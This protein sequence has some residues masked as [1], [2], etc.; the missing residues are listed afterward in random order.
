MGQPIHVLRG[1]NANVGAVAF[2]P[3][4][5]R[6][7]SGG[8][9]TTVV[10]WDLEKGRPIRIRPSL[11]MVWYLAVHPDNT[12]VASAGPAGVL[13]WDLNSGRQVNV[14]TEL[15]KQ[16]NTEWVGFTRDGKELVAAGPNGA[17]GLWDTKSGKLLRPFE[18]HKGRVFSAALSPDGRSLLS[19]GEDKTVRLW[20][21]DN[22]E[23]VRQFRGVKDVI[24]AVAFS[25]DG[26]RVLA[27]GRDPSILLWDTETGNGPITM[28]VSGVGFWDAA[29]A[30]DGKRILTASGEG[31]DNRLS[32]WWLPAQATAKA[33]RP[34]EAPAP[35]GLKGWEHCDISQAVVRGDFLH[36]EPRRGITTRQAF[37][38]P[39]QITAVARTER[40]N[41]RI[42]AGSGGELIFNWEGKP[43]EL[44]VHRPDARVRRRL[45]VLAASKQ[46]PLDPNTWYMLTWT[47]TAR[48]MEVEV[49]GK[50]VFQE[51]H[52]ND[53]SQPRP[54]RIYAFVDSAIDVQRFT[55]RPLGAGA[56]SKR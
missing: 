3:D 2:C 33:N 43:G 46:V 12:L 25:P 35:V 52:D 7:V 36:L 38:G 4:G 20:N 37:A 45:G 1:H 14:G 22:A 23:E 44:R 15:S 54:V 11:G 40:N 5:K 49:N 28:K 50:P 27:A 16:V 24:R 29:F 26:K 48:G 32:L 6:A 55:V 21:L 9:D 10:L 42:R 41:I 19:G 39:I 18:G 53:L 51:V 13:L 8:D 34:A 17:L 30:P 47:I 56:G 31:G